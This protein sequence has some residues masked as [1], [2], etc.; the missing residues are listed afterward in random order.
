[1][2]FKEK[3]ILNH[4]IK[5]WNIFNKLDRQH[6]DELRDFCDGIH[7]CQYLIGMRIARKIEPK[8]FQ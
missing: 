2:T 6:P 5:A 1:M 7:R 3:E 4:L 8:I